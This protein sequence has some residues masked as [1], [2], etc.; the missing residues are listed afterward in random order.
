MVPTASGLAALGW[1]MVGVL[2]GVALVALAG[3]LMRWRQRELARRP[4]ALDSP[5]RGRAEVELQQA[6]RRITELGADLERER[7]AAASAQRAK[8]QFFASASHDLR[9]PLHALVLFTETLRQQA[10]DPALQPLLRNI[11]ASVQALEVLFD[12]V[13]DLTRIDSGGVPVRPRAFA[14]QEVY[15]R[16]RLHVEPVAF[17]KGL[18]LRWRGGAHWVQADPALVERILRNLVGNAIRY[19]EDGGVLVGCRRRGE[20]VW[21]Q[22]WDSGIGIREAALPQIFD[23]FYQVSGTRALEPQHRKGVGLGLAIVKRLADLMAAPL[24]LRSVVGCG[25]VFQLE[26]PGAAAGVQ[27]PQISAPLRE[28]PRVDLQGRCI[29]VVEDE[30]AV[31]LGLT[32]LL[33]GWGAQVRGFDRHAAVCAAAQA[34]LD[35]GLRAPDLLIVDHSLPEARTGVAVVEALRALWG[36]AMPVIMVTGQVLHDHRADAA[37]L[38]YHVLLKPVA[39]NRLRAMVTHK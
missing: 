39:P 14:M 12:E 8:T 22:V 29:W 38:G 2:A 7:A 19:T 6:R 20:R 28:W 36:D 5:E 18:T 1:V 33:E 23:E 37:R 21:L 26:L 31:Q 15:D 4:T 34:R 13:L 10:R 9:Q 30:P 11:T 27:P 3:G 32:G 17:D 35:A 24:T 25:T 16:L